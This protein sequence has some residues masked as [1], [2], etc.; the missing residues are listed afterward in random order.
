MAEEIEKNQDDEEVLEFDQKDAV[1]DVDDD[2]PE[3]TTAQAPAKN[4]KKLFIIIGVAV[5]VLII[6]IVVVVLLMSKGEEAPS[7][8]LEEKPIAEKIVQLKDKSEETPKTKIEEMIKK[9][10]MLYEKGYKQEALELF[11]SISSYSESLSYYNIGVAHMKE[12]NYKSALEAFKIAIQNADN[13]C[14]SAI[15]AAV[16]ALILNNKDL[17]S[18]YI[19]LA[20][21]N[22]PKSVHDPLYKYY[23]ALVTYYKGEYIESLS[24]LKNDNNKIYEKEQN[25]IKAN[26][27]LIFN[28]NITAIEALESTATKDD[29]MTL[30]L[31]FAREGIYDMSIKYLKKAEKEFPDNDKLRIALGIINTKVGNMSNASAYFK[32]LYKKSGNEPMKSYPITVYIK[33]TIF[34]KNLAQDEFA[35]RMSLTNK[36]AYDILIYFAPYKIFNSDKTIGY[37]RKGNKSIYIDAINDAKSDYQKS[38]VS[39]KVNS[40]TSKAIKLATNYHIREANKLLASII[41][42]FPND[43]ILHYNLALSYAQMQIYNKAYDHFSKSFHLDQ[44]NTLSGVFAVMCGELA[45][46]D[47]KILLND[48]K[49]SLGNKKTL[50]PED[51]F[52]S[53][54]I[55]YADGNYQSAIKWLEKND[56]DTVLANVFEIIVSGK[57]EKYSM[58]LAKVEEFKKLLN[59]DIIANILYIYAKNRELSNKEFA[60][61]ANYFLK[62]H[63]MFLDS[64]YYGP[65]VVKEMYIT[66]ANVA[67]MSY[68]IRDILKERVMTEIVDVRGVMQSLALTN[69]YLN[70]FEEAYT[71]YNSLIDSLKEDD[72]HTLFLAAVSAIG[73]NHHA[74]A[75]AL[76]ELANLADSKNYEARYALG[77]LYLEANNIEAAGIQFSRIDDNKFKSDFFDFDIRKRDNE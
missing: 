20:Y 24:A 1:V 5:L 3:E 47:Y 17:F 12:E 57:L 30:G 63:E 41:D 4:K 52:H 21:S 27:A 66:L 26:L 36:M 10:N 22:L 9:A 72:T 70:F 19:D 25:H 13:I 46:V 44:K 75:I 56:Q 33:D 8:K 32:D 68:T 60:K 77:L 76:L 29:F 37:I 64:L 42:E 6:V 15:N 55:N 74:E 69:I 45:H 54:L 43:S 53:M 71:I 16:C 65:V 38:T 14:V 28:D 23:Y 50:S 7:Q 48:V 49:M 51:E 61:K 59:D 73:A 31:L 67:G 2:K 40:V 35:K 18:Y 58:Q 11:E 39:A 62:E 34:D